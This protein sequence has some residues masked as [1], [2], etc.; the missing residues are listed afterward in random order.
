METG[1]A[2]TLPSFG[3][4]KVRFLG[5]APYYGLMLEAASI[6]ERQLTPTSLSCGEE[7]S[8]DTVNVL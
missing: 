2:V 3:S 5:D 1:Q 7:T 8:P 6:I 4:R